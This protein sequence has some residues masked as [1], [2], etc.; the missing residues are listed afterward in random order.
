VPLRRESRSQG[1]LHAVLGDGEGEGE[2]S[3]GAGFLQ[4]EEGEDE[5]EEGEEKAEEEAAED[6]YEAMSTV[7]RRSRDTREMPE[8]NQ[9]SH[10]PTGAAEVGEG[11][12]PGEEEEES[13]SC[14]PTL[15]EAEERGSRNSEWGLWKE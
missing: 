8:G 15:G 12:G 14:R 2:E 7:R 13:P 5:E 9:A 10:G 1:R 3:G 11:A 4:E 6:E